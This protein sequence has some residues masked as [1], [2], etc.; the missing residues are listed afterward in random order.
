M[1][2]IL[3]SSKTII[4]S[5]PMTVLI[6]WATMITVASAVSIFNAARKRAS[7]LKSRAEKLSSRI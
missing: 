2:T 7:V 5:A 3:P 6:R 1:P 4:R